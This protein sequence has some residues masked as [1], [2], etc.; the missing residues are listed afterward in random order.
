LGAKISSIAVSNSTNVTVTAGSATQL[1]FSNPPSF[2]G[3]T[4][5]ALAVQPAITAKDAYNNTAP[6]YSGTLT[7]KG[8]SDSSCSTE[9]PSSVVGTTSNSAGVVSFSGVK[10]LKTNVVAIK[11]TDGTLSTTCLSGFAISPGAL[12]SLVFSAQPSASAT[13]GTAFATQPSVTAY[14]ANLNPLVTATPITL[15]LTSGT[16][17]LACTTNPVSTD[18][19]GVATFAGCKLTG[20][21]GN[22]TLKASAGAINTTS[23]TITLAQASL[24]LS[25][26]AEFGSRNVGTST[27]VVMTV[28]NQNSTPTSG[29]SA[30]LSGTNPGDFSIVSDSCA[31]SVSAS[32]SCQLTVQA[33]PTTGGLRTATLNYTCTDGASASSNANAVKVTGISRPSLAF[34]ITG[35]GWPI[36]SDFGPVNISTSTENINR[37]GSINVTLTNSGEQTAS[38]C[39]VT[40][41]DP[42]NFTL[43]TLSSCSTLA[44]NQSCA[45]N[46]RPNPTTAGIHHANL[47]VN[48]ASGVSAISYENG[49][50][51]TG[52]VAPLLLMDGGLNWASIPINSGGSGGLM[53]TNYG[54]ADA[55]GCSATLS[56]HSDFK[57]ATSPAA[58][59][60][61]AANSTG[62][63]WVEISPTSLGDRYAT[64]TF[65]CSGSVQATT[66]T[67]GIH[68]FVVPP[69]PALTRPV[70]AYFGTVPPQKH[71]TLSV[72]I[73]NT[74]GTN[75]TGCT[76]SVSNP[77]DFKIPHN[78]SQCTTIPANG[79]CLLDVKTH[80][81]WRGYTTVSNVVSDLQIS[82]QNASMN[83]S[84]LLH[85]D[86]AFPYSNYSLTFSGDTHDFGILQHGASGSPYLGLTVTNP[87]NFDLSACTYTVSAPVWQASS[88]TI[89]SSPGSDCSTLTAGQSCTLRVLPN[90]SRYYGIRKASVSVICYSDWVDG[91]SSQ[92]GLTLFIDKAPSVAPSGIIQPVYQNGINWMDY[93]KRDGTTVY[94][95]SDTPCD[96][97]ESSL[98]NCIHGGEIRKYVSSYTSCDGL[99]AKDALGAFNWICD[100][101]SGTAIFYSVGLK[102]GKGLRDLVGDYAFLQNKLM[103]TDHLNPS[104]STDFSTWWTNPVGPVNPT[105]AYLKSPGAIS[106]FNDDAASTHGQTLQGLKIALVNLGQNPKIL[107]YLRINS[108]VFCW[109]EGQ[110]DT[111]HT[112][113][114]YFSPP[115]LRT[116]EMMLSQLRNLSLNQKILVTKSVGNRVSNLRV[117]AN[118]PVIIDLQDQSSSNAFVQGITSGKSAN[119]IRT[120]WNSRRNLFSR[121][122]LFSY[123]GWA[124]IPYSS[125]DSGGSSF[126]LITAIKEGGLSSSW[127]GGQTQSQIVYKMHSITYSG[128][129]SYHPYEGVYLTGRNF[130]QKTLSNVFKGRI[131]SGVG[132][133]GDSANKVSPWGGWSPEGGM[134]P[135]DV[136][137]FENPFRAF[138]GMFEN[139][140]YIWD[141]SLKSTATALLNRSGDG[142]HLNDAFTVGDNCPYA[143]YVPYSTPEFNYLVNAAEIPGTGGND[144]GYC[145]E[146]ETCVF[147]PNFGSYL[148]SGGYTNG[149]CTF[150]NPNGSAPI[151]NVKLYQYNTTAEP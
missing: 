82:C 30:S 91:S 18:A 104:S 145:E 4:D 31:G 144:N 59:T 99:T 92:D 28:I 98:S 93:V 56:G 100:D 151:Q 13:S 103:I 118:S 61:I 58:A 143:A 148:G 132:G 15:S 121:M 19:N 72:S 25:P 24:T 48:C 2:I 12:S 27:Q 43:T 10:I 70:D 57:I 69:P 137:N 42:T 40:I 101:S 139:E 102:E 149:T 55:T 9:V 64:L 14:D 146:G 23:N 78:G 17:T 134:P 5:L 95:A 140:T 142:I 49:I 32:G 147:Q 119:D 136:W 74:G 6:T 126:S 79:S 29:C 125:R 53:V 124:S 113:P 87:G 96:F 116:N 94:N 52:Q 106:T 88:F 1:V 141:L 150:T 120:D 63:V 133:S 86:E 111:R 37:L 41:T 76:Y 105:Q 62:F 47:S 127:R 39:V 135:P 36:T 44:A 60:T 107:D 33:A 26:G 71:K 35:Y 109:L 117:H 54:S 50:S 89:D 75:A 3:N 90:T 122:T 80:P 130:I 45:L 51:V 65:S 84:A 97:N 131:D 46:F 68:A 67:D 22:Y 128:G 81:A 34:S 21:A 108:C 83:H 123:V 85:V 115:G 11:A 138:F 110:Y 77:N 38:S 129:V 66:N 20:S 73:F 112:M 8:Y 114:N 7:L 16:P